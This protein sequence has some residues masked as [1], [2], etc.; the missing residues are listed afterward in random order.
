MRIINYALKWKM[1]VDTGMEKVVCSHAIFQ[2][3]ESIFPQ[4]KVAIWDSSHTFTLQQFGT[5]TNDDFY[6]ASMLYPELFSAIIIST[7][8]HYPPS[9]SITEGKDAISLIEWLHLSS[10]EILASFSSY[11]HLIYSLIICAK[12]ILDVSMHLRMSSEK[13][14]AILYVKEIISFTMYLI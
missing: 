14:Q 1:P 7:K 10:I 6:K 13:R 9:F 11:K 12:T 4:F 2:L 3:L 5:F 8:P